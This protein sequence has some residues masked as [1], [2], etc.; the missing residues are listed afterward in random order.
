MKIR[1]GNC[2]IPICLAFFLFSDFVLELMKDSFER[3]FFKEK[4]KRKVLDRPKKK[5]K[6]IL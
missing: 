6:K 1:I 3:E 5:T 4:K 2:R